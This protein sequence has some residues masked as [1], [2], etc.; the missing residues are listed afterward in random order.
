MYKELGVYLRHMV[1]QGSVW[2]DGE[3]WTAIIGGIAT[4]YWFYRD[5]DSVTAVRR[6]FGDIL[7]I[8]SI[9]FGFVLTA[10]IFYVQ[11]AGSWSTD[12]RVQRVARKLIDWHVWTIVCLLA[13]ISYVLVLWA[14]G[15]FVQVGRVWKGVQYGI[16]AFLMLYCGLQILNHALTIWWTFRERERL[17]NGPPD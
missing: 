15:P 13:L 14:T 12:A 5:P 1:R 11:A 3:L 8:A 16:L 9:I 4:G 17:E 2:K 7:T 6:H 10:L